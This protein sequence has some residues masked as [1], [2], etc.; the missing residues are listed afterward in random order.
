MPERPA[1][2]GLKYGC[3]KFKANLKCN[4]GSKTRERGSAG[5]GSSHGDKVLGPTEALDEVHQRT[6]VL[7]LQDKKLQ[8]HVVS[9][10]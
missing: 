3:L 7:R 8:V 9:L 10:I 4:N 1:L 6:R 5:G 2:K